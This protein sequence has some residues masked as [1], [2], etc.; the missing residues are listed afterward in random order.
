MFEPT[1]GLYIGITTVPISIVSYI[2]AFIALSLIL[3]RSEDGKQFVD[4]MVSVLLIGILTYK[5]WFIIEQ[6]SI[7]FKQPLEILMYSGGAYAWEATILLCGAWLSY[8]IW[9]EAPSNRW[10]LIQRILFAFIIVRV[11]YSLLIKDYGSP[12]S[13]WGWRLDDQTYL[14][15]NLFLLVGYL[16]LLLSFYVL[17][18]KLSFNKDQI[19]FWLIGISI[20]EL[21]VRGFK[22]Q[23]DHLWMNIGTLDILYIVTLLIGVYFL[24]FRQPDPIHKT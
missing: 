8:Q 10:R 9:K 7:L 23:L 6:P 1:E 15:T 13:G 11:S 14:P 24:L 16:L 21:V 2:I 4:K 12:S 18:K 5:F 22:P 3:S 19:S 20:I 17:R